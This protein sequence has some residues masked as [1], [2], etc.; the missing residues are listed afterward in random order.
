MQLRSAISG[1]SMVLIV[2]SLLTRGPDVAAN[3]MLAVIGWVTGGRFRLSA[4]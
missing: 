2:A 1:R 3:E 4:K